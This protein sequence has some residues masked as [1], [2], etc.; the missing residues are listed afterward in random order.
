VNTITVTR[1]ELTPEERAKRM[2]AIKQAAVRL[3]LE[4]EKIKRRKE[5]TA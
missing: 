1:P 5:K 4:T 3:V 2:E